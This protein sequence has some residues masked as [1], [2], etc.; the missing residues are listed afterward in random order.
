MLEQVPWGGA[1]TS[2]GLHE[3]YLPI[4][5]KSGLCCVHKAH[6]PAVEENYDVSASFTLEKSM[7]DIAHSSLSVYK[8]FVH[9]LISEFLADLC[10]ILYSF[11]PFLKIGITFAIFQF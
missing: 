11:S 6:H 10:K 1:S 8:Q 4:T 5:E 3:H 9:S 7:P 2:G